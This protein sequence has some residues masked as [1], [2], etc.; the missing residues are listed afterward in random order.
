[1]LD[2]FEAVLRVRAVRSE[3]CF[4]VKLH[5]RT[6]SQGVPLALFIRHQ[7]PAKL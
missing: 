7:K 2:S 3:A 5:V 1:L 4:E 6:G